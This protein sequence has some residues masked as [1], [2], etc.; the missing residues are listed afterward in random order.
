M[1]TPCTVH[2]GTQSVVPA[3]TVARDNLSNY[4][5]SS[6]VKKREK[7]ISPSLAQ[8]FSSSNLQQSFLNVCLKIYSLEVQAMFATLYTPT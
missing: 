1:L 4:L 3:A 5:L 7:I 6:L 2:K 8:H